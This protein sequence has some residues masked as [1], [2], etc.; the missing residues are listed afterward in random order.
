MSLEED[1]LRDAAILNF[2]FEDVK[3]IVL[4]IIV[5]GALADTVVLVGALNYGLL[6]VGLEVK[7]LNENFKSLMF[8]DIPAYRA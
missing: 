2:I 7:N 8:N 4:K 1:T 3:S 6:E 5:N